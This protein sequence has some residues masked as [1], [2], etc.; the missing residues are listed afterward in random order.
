MNTQVDVAR[1]AA[2][3]AGAAVLLWIAL[4]AGSAR[5]LTQIDFISDPGD[6]IGGGQTF[7]L[8]PSDGSFVTTTQ[9]S[10]VSISFNAPEPGA[11]SPKT[12]W[13]LVFAPAQGMTLTP[14]NYPSA[15]RWPFQ[16]PQL[17]GLEIFGDGRGC[18]ALTGKFTVYEAVFDSAG[19]V[20]SFA[21]D[22]E[23]HC[24]AAAPALRVHV[25]INSNVPLVQAA[26]QSIPGHPQGVYERS[27]VTLDGSQSYDP[28]GQIV[29][30]RWSQLSGP[31]V[32]IKSAT[33]AIATFTAPGVPPG[34]ADVA[35]QLT[36][37]NGSGQ[38]AS[39]AVTEHIFN[40]KDRRTLLTFVSPPGDYIGQGQALTLTPY[41]VGVTLQPGFG[42]PSVQIVFDGGA[43]NN[44][45]IDLEAPNGAA[46]LPGTYTSAER[47]PIQSPGKPGLSF[48]GDGRGCNTIAGQFTVFEFDP[49][50]NPVRF[51]A[52]FKQSCEGFMPSL[53]GTVL[54]NSIMPSSRKGRAQQVPLDESDG[55][56]DANETGAH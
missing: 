12:S 43:F 15:Q 26:P 8:T 42:A 47:F 28:S 55:S 35:L 32:K 34:G 11:V 10:A 27:L 13:F 36:V 54:Y 23:Q 52:T 1:A 5:A 31:K 4:A 18:N 46:P 50:T 2:R 45:T 30:W 56:F 37:K 40:L 6:Y 9:G 39:A 48:F 44:W 33:S 29:S 41:E 7:S 16:S 20:V 17:P 53:T 49:T 51:G 14:G 19:Q 22:A 21:V 38:T 25:R 3:C 24:E